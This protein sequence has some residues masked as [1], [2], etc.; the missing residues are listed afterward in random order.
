MSNLQDATPAAVWSR[1]DVIAASA[2]MLRS[3]QTV[4]GRP[5]LPASGDAA[6]DAR[7]LFE[8]PFAVL[9]HGTQ[10][11]PIFFYGNATALRLWDMS[12]DAFTRMPS[13]LSAEPGL[14][15]ERQRLLAQA[16]RSGFID[17]YAGVRISRSGARF[18]I[19]KV[20]LWTLA[21][22]SGAS[23]GQA[24]WIPDWTAL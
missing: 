11:D 15:D 22:E 8:A 1:P 7:A 18:R 16:A 24:A 10:P 14:R 17:D 4:V 21:D 23:H 12:F 13:R 20:I 19:E 6:Y 3:F 9:A 2:L 5:L